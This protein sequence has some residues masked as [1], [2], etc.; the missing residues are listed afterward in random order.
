MKD[1]SP[2]FCVFFKECVSNKP[3]FAWKFSAKLIN[4]I[5]LI[6]TSNVVGA[7]KSKEVV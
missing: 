2:N 3:K 5:K 6:Y 7:E 4:W 1:N